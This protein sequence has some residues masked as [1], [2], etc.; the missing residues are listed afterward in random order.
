LK[1]NNL[2]NILLSAL[3]LLN[4]AILS[5]SENDSISPAR[6]T[7]GLNFDSSSESEL[8]PKRKKFRFQSRA[9]RKTFK[10]SNQ[11]N[12]KHRNKAG[13]KRFKNRHSGSVGHQNKVFKKKK[14]KGKLKKKNF[15][16]MNSRH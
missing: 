7:Q 1:R 4:S 11:F 5:G 3:F 8:K 6:E 12:K 10:L 13:K 9:L 14:N 2:I 16:D 15:H